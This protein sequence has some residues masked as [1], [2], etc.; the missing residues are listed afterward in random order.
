MNLSVVVITKNAERLLKKSL[1]SIK[2]LADEIIVVDNNSTDKTLAIA[3]KYKTKIYSTDINSFGRQKKFGVSKAKNEWVLV[4]DSDEIV[5][6]P[7]KREI[8]KIIGKPTKFYGFK[9]PYQ[10]HLFGKPIYYG[11]EDY[12]KLVLFKKKYGVIKNELVHESFQVKNDNYGRLKN[13][14]FHYSYANLWQMYSKFTRYAILEAKQKAA[15]HEQSSL[16]KIFAYPI[17]MF[18]AR[19]IK[20]KGYKDYWPRIF[21]DLGFAYM[22][23]LTY[24]YLAILNLKK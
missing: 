7:L 9:I 15:N 8:K 21:L 23:F 14:I 17:H 4:L 5:S 1:A 6:Q 12:S 22:E 20:D 11:G 10:N 3:K 24:I 19:Y 2:N 16:K 18:W 13:K